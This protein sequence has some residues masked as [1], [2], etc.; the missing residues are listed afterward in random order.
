MLEGF[1]AGLAWIV[2]LRK[3]DAF[4]KAFSDFD[5][6]VVYRGQGL[7][8]QWEVFASLMSGPSGPPWYCS[9]H[10]RIFF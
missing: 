2:V 6:L 10:C 3:R 8:G 4:R 5:T 1:Q 9:W 7:A